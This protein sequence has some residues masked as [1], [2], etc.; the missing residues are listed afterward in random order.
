MSVYDSKSLP[1]SQLQLIHPIQPHQQQTQTNGLKNRSIGQ[2]KKPSQNS[3]TNN[4]NNQ[5][6]QS[7]QYYDL[8]GR[9][10][11]KRPLDHLF[12]HMRQFKNMFQVIQVDFL[13]RILYNSYET[14]FNRPPSNAM[15]GNGDDDD[16]E[17]NFSKQFANK[18]FKRLRKYHQK[19]YDLNEKLF[20][21]IN[22]PTNCD[23]K[24]LSFNS[25]LPIKYEYYKHGEYILRLTG[26]IIYKMRQCLKLSEKYYQ[27]N[28][29]LNGEDFVSYL[30]DSNLSYPQSQSTLSS[31]PYIVDVD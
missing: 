16:G 29:K 24:M 2:F 31:Y 20:V 17:N 3:L 13:N 5:M 8:N 15:H 19:L 10:A 22:D 11:N 30:N 27:L 28:F 1:N 21:L 9:H 25:N 14:R 4:S 23:I 6:T 12:E 26:D 18:D 7:N